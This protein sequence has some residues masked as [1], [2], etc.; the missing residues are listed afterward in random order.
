MNILINSFNDSNVNNRQ[1]LNS[2]VDSLV[3]IIIKF[4]C[5]RIDFDTNWTS[6]SFYDDNS[7]WI[8]TNVSNY[9]SDSS[10]II[11]ENSI[12]NNNSTDNVNGSVVI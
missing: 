11:A 10:T 12:F 1:Y 7:S 4:K 2:T 3:N 6:M 8:C 5:L 9:P